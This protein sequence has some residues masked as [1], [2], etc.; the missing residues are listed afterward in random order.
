MPKLADR[1]LQ[2][3]Y[4]GSRHRSGY[5][6]VPSGFVPSPGHRSGYA[7]AEFGFAA[8][9]AIV[10]ARNSTGYHGSVPHTTLLTVGAGVPRTAGSLDPGSQT[11][12]ASPGGPTVQWFPA[13]KDPVEPAVADPF[14]SR[15]CLTFSVCG[16]S[17]RVRR[18]LAVV[19]NAA[20]DQRPGLAKS[21][22][23]A[24]QALEIQSPTAAALTPGR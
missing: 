7:Q 14:A 6:C 3:S 10:D 17:C 15:R 20:A 21:P 2:G 23:W 22:S 4:R 5:G 8:P 18:S 12:F 24:R 19:G 16:G 9:A 1:R 13:T 11:P